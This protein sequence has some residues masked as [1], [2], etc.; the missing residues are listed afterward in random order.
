LRALKPLPNTEMIYAE[1]TV[2]TVKGSGLRCVSVSNIA[3]RKKKSGKEKRLVKRVV[4]NMK[5]DEA[6]FRKLLQLGGPIP[7]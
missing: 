4:K 1:I 3:I 2:V 7:V 5:F 6:N